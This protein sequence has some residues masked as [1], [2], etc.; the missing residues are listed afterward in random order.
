[1][2]CYLLVSPISARFASLKE[3]RTVGRELIAKVRLKSKRLAIALPLEGYCITMR[4]PSVPWM[5]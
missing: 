5:V 2:N 3:Q 1:M 4:A